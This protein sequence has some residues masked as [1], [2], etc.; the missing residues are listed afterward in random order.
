MF[1][2]AFIALHYTFADTLLLRAGLLF[3]L[4]PDFYSFQLSGGTDCLT[5]AAAIAF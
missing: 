4:F 3:I 2:P 5:G 1:A